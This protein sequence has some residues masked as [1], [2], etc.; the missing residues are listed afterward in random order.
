MNAVSVSVPVTGATRYDISKAPPFSSTDW[1]IQ[2]FDARRHVIQ[3]VRDVSDVEGVVAALLAQEWMVSRWHARSYIRAWRGDSLPVTRIDCRFDPGSS[4]WR[5]QKWK[6]GWTASTEPA[7]DYLA[8]SNWEINEALAWFAARPPQD[9]GDPDGWFVRRVG[10]QFVRAWL[11]GR[12]PCYNDG[13]IVRRRRQ[14]EVWGAYLDAVERG[15]PSAAAR[16]V[17]RPA[18][19]PPDVP[20]EMVQKSI[21][22]Q[23]GEIDLAYDL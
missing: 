9:H 10:Q 19:I 17:E 22:G 8:P 15:D 20:L 12:K 3:E 16:R 14:V 11:G 6:A 21:F 23:A 7:R 18:W 1:A 2:A 13:T 4:R 5:I